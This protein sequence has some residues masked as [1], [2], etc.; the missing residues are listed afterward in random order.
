MLK[1]DIKREYINGVME[2]GEKGERE[3]WWRERRKREKGR[4]RERG[5][6]KEEGRDGL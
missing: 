5:R 2:G 6:G 1:G 3:I 4:L